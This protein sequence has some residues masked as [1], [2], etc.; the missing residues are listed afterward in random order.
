MGYTHYWKG[1]ANLDNQLIDELNNL[2]SHGA[3]NRIIQK[4]YDQ[5]Q[6]PDLV[7]LENK[8]LRFNGI[9]DE[10]HET[11]V[12]VFNE[13]LDFEFCKTAR[14]P[15]DA[16]VVA[17]LILITEANE[18]TGGDFS[19]SSNGDEGEGDFKEGKKLADQFR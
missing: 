1:K 16:Y 15:Y 12:V 8:R 10:G 7:S 3:L 19:W 11:F 5:A 4:E 6:V 9:E 17:S 14:K 2:V 18:R 13:S